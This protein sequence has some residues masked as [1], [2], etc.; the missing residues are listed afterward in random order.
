MILY[1]E[2]ES[3]S[4]IVEF[5]AKIKFIPDVLKY[6]DDTGNGRQIIVICLKKE[7]CPYPIISPATSM[8]SCYYSLAPKTQHEYYR[9]FSEFLNYVYFDAKLIKSISEVRTE[10]IISFLN[11]QV[12]TGKGRKYVDQTKSN[13][14]KIF[15]HYSNDYADL[16]LIDNTEFTY[17]SNGKKTKIIWPK[18]DNSVLLP[19]KK[20]D[21][22]NRVNKIT[23]IDMDLVFLFLEVAYEETPNCALGFYFLFFAGI[24]GDE[25]LHLTSQDIPKRYNGKS[26]FKIILRDKLLNMDSKTSDI[27]QNKH[28]RSQLVLYVPELYDKLYLQWKEKYGQGSIVR[29]HS[30]K[31]MTISGFEKRF[32]HVKKILIEKLREGSAEDKIRAFKLEQFRWSTHMGRGFL[33][34]LVAEK[35]DNPYLVSVIRGDSDFAS[36]LPYISESESTVKSITDHLESIYSNIRNKR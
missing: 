8:V 32:N 4:N 30:N 29:N 2:G 33:S 23:N 12:Q 5:P 19:S 27:A 22:E 11:Y 18:V 20:K 1:R 35:T 13:L 15:Y 21:Y 28:E 9:R 36:A 34:N 25:T 31:P 7:G 3:M 16:S 10:H 26:H 17:V 24:R 6:I 14:T